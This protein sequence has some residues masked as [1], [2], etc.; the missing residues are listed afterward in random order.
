MFAD[1]LV[2]QD[3][4]GD[5][6]EESLTG[7]AAV[8]ERILE[9]DGASRS[10]VTLFGD[11][12]HLAVGGDSRSGLVV[13][14]TFDNESFHELTNPAA[15]GGAAVTVVAGGQPGEYPP[16]RV[17]AAD[18]AITAA[19]EFARSGGLAEGLTWQIS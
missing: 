19:L 8:R 7:E 1:L 2:S 6:V 18:D 15:E 11:E 5:E 13:Y 3:A 12:A 17:V 16:A 10:L 14:A 9:L 4:N